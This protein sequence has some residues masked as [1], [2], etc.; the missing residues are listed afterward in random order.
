MAP[1]PHF[2]SCE[3]EALYGVFDGRYKYTY[4]STPVWRHAVSEE[5]TP[6][7]HEYVLPTGPDESIDRYLAPLQEKGILGERY[8]VQ[9]ELYDL[10][11]DPGETEN[12]AE[13]EP[14]IVARLHALL[15]RRMFMDDPGSKID[16][17]RVGLAFASQQ[18][19]EH[20]F[21]IASDGPLKL[22]RATGAC[23]R[24]ELRRLDANS[25]EVR[26]TIGP[27]QWGGVELYRAE[28]QAIRIHAEREGDSRPYQEAVFGGSFG[29]P[30]FSS[31]VEGNLTLPP[32]ALPAPARMRPKIEAKDEGLFV[33]RS[34]DGR[35][36]A[37]EL[38]AGLE[39]VF[40]EWG[41]AK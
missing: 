26:C 23:E 8:Q 12:L 24:G 32:D 41:Y 5:W 9:R 27:G 25:I 19:A 35:P 20:R 15:T 7:G 31:F 29:L 28:S 6:E 2:F 39:K 17:A 13:R 11:N 1:A 37:G 10:Q 33:Y 30:L 36:G 21:T 4:F 38:T 18:R 22:E 34:T 3:A 14:E 16:L 40:A